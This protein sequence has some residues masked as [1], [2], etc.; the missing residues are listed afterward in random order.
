M[1][2]NSKLAVKAHLNNRCQSSML[3]DLE[4]DIYKIYEWQV[5]MQSNFISG[6]WGS[7][8]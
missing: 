5:K 3:F 7:H 2:E 4:D 1:I 8:L 6:Y